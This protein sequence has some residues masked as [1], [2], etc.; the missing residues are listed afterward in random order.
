MSQQKEVTF[1]D[2]DDFR[3]LREVFEKAGYTDRSILDVLGVR[4]F[5]SLKGTDVPLL[6]RRT[7]EQS[8]LHTLIRLFLIETGCEADAVRDAFHPLAPETLIK[9]GIVRIDSDVVTAAVKILPYRGLYIAFDLPSLLRS[10]QKKDYVMGIGSSTLTLANLT[11]RKPSRLTLDL[12]TGCGIHAFLAAGH[13][14]S[15]LATDLNP[16]A[17]AFAAFNARLNNMSHVHCLQGDLFVPVTGRTFDL[18]VS[19]P[20][21]VISP[22]SEYIYRDGGLEGDGIT[23]KIVSQV[24]QYLNEGGY[25]QILC[26]W[27]ELSGQDWKDRLHSWFEGTG[28]DAWVLRSESLDAETY[29]LTWIRHTEKSGTGQFS[30]QFEKWMAYYEAQGIVSMG[31]GV[32]TMRRNS[33]STNWFRADEAPER[34]LGPCGEHI[35]RGFASR[36]FLQTVKDDAMLLETK[37]SISP[38]VRLERKARP[39]DKGWADEMMQLR[40]A[41][42]LSFSGN[43]DPYMANL[44]VKCDGTR[45]LGDLLDE[46]AKALAADT[47]SL[48][49]AFCTIIRDLVGRGFLLP[50]GDG[51]SA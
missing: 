6:L 32:I 34:M 20:P 19:N 40:L 3:R 2:P 46:M 39:A 30:V 33:G 17:L 35:V 43:I 21:F 16:R 38:D 8:P 1:D 12:G 51:T 45:P 42:G 29:A 14:G 27:A 25:C 9:A 48:A 37:L 7:K 28:C 41:Q 26:N 50:P 44:I 4:D 11:V 47:D 31:A 36:D 24:P 49:P 10:G 5:P 18:V 23:R 15:V 13:S 22:E